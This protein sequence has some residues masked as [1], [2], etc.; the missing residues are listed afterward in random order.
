MK[1][2]LVL[3]AAESVRV[4]RDTLRVPRRSMLRFSVLPLTTVA[5]LTPPR[6]Q[7]TL[8][9]ENVE[10][11]DLDADVD[12]VG[13]TFMTAL[14]PRA[15]EIAD[16]FRARG[17]IV[18]A[19]GYHPTFLPEEAAT[20]FDAVVVGEAEGTWPEVL[21]DV[22]AGRLHR[23]YRRPEPCDP[24]EIPAPRRELTERT[25]RYYVTV[26]AVQ[27][28]RG[29]RHA[30]RYCSVTAFHRATHRS[31]P[32]GRVLEEL[33]GVPRDFMFV[34]D[35]ILA[36]PE[37]ARELFRAMVPFGK[38]WVGQCSLEIA[39]DPALLQLAREAG[40]IGLFIG[41]ETLSGANLVAVEKGF[42]DSAGYLGR[43]A[44]IRRAGIGIVAGIIVGMDGDDTGTFERTL[45]FL[46]RARIDAVQVNVMTP[47][48]GTPLF[49][50]F[51][52]QGR[53]LDRDY[54]RYD[55]RHC[56]IRPERMTPEELQDGAD[57]LYARFY[58]GDRI[59]LRFARALFTLGPAAA[60]LGLRLGITYRYDNRREG[61]VG[62]NPA[63]SP[64]R[65]PAEALL[66]GADSG[67]LC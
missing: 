20:H 4:T 30:C 42:N 66:E 62:R 60:R 11:L 31:R 41:I 39:D 36:D 53:V 10:A 13:I 23:I 46:D 3:P 33:A 17:R 45:R 19:G 65:A 44:A 59:L 57:W 25:A 37:Y 49:E 43:I 47:L 24:V 28:G 27:T 7:V 34:D 16:A 1:I 22:E 56:V 52:R 29:C 67:I 26:H 38:R 61:I 35:N 14:A 12:V 40:C 64:V 15:Y 48:P 32:L 58:R 50:T 2:L 55:F 9:D 51:E 63:S 5:A 8:C 6:H 54:A 21:E 18:V